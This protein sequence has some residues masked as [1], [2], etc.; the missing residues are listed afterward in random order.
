SLAPAEKPAG[1][2]DPAHVVGLLPAPPASDSKR[3]DEK[4]SSELQLKSGGAMINTSPPTDLHPSQSD[5]NTKTAPRSYSTPS[6][7]SPIDGVPA[8]ETR[9]NLETAHAGNYAYTE[10]PTKEGNVIDP[11]AGEPRAGYIDQ[12][13]AAMSS[14]ATNPMGSL[15][16]ALTAVGLGGAAGA[17]AVA[18]EQKDKAVKEK[19]PVEEID[20]GTTGKAAK[21]PASTGGNFLAPEGVVGSRFPV[22]EDVQAALAKKEGEVDTEKSGPTVKDINAAAKKEHDAVAEVGGRPTGPVH[23]SSN[24]I[25]TTTNTHESKAAPATSPATA[26]GESGSPK[27]E[28]PE[29]VGKTHVADSFKN[30]IKSAAQE[31]KPSSK[32]HD[33]KPTITTTTN[34]QEKAAP[35]TS[36]ATSVEARTNPLDDKT[37][38]AASVPAPAPTPAPASQ[39][40]PATI[41]ARVDDHSREATDTTSTTAT[42][43]STPTSP[44][45]SHDRRPSLKD[46][47]KGEM[48]VI[49]GKLSRNEAKIEEGKALKSGGLSATSAVNSPISPARK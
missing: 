3:E 38:G 27:H 46:R 35:A 30:T 21:S 23:T 42:T 34:T 39:A 33:D 22:D 29:A 25:Q 31:V 1:P 2:E 9:A 10:L 44:T 41:K 14:V 40:V 47:I 15:A 16:G 36:P 12:A 24:P 43:G 19:E 4:S 49:T 7:P 26:V 6:G 37:T 45:K 11:H 8:G 48:K 17:T 20:T 13:R 5:E 18:A 32:K 28:H